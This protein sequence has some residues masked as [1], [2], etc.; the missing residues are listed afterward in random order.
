MRKAISLLLALFMV[1]ALCAC[2]SSARENTS[3]KQADF[4]V[5]GSTESEST[6]A[7]QDDFTVEDFAVDKIYGGDLYF[8]LKVRN[9]TD[10]NYEFVS[11][12]YQLL[13]E[14][15]SALTKSSFGTLSFPANQANWLGSYSISEGN[16]ENAD[17]IRFISYN[18][19][20]NGE[21][22]FFSKSAEF[23]L[24][25]Y[26]DIAASNTD[27][28]REIVLDEPVFLYEDEKVKLT[29]NKLFEKDKNDSEIPD[30]CVEFNVENK[31]EYPVFVWGIYFYIDDQETFDLNSG[32]GQTTIYAGK[33]AE[34]YFIIRNDADTPLASLEELYVADGVMSIEVM[35]A[36]GKMIIEHLHIP[37]S[38]DITE[39]VA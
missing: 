14:D 16:W 3:E 32:K 28:N 2:G 36:E 5:E 37:F 12:Y 22:V 20:Q 25:E 27:E 26:V 15:G 18:T 17:S 10:R 23:S 8:K 13:D 39:Q 29:L 7:K 1:L 30:K 34:R 4:T 33:S 35:N 31:T 9:N 38:Y 11:I 24:E 6:S 21:Y 19:S